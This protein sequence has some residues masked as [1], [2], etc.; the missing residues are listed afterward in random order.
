MLEI[1]L[2]NQ[3]LH[4]PNSV[5]TQNYFISDLHLEPDHNQELGQHF[6]AFLHHLELALQVRL[7]C[8]ATQL[9][10]SQISPSNLQPY[11]RL[12]IHGDLLNLAYADSAALLEARF[13]ASLQRLRTQYGLEIYFMPG[14]RDFLLQEQFCATIGAQ[15][16]PE[17]SLLDWVSDGSLSINWA[18]APTLQHPMRAAS[19]TYPEFDGQRARKLIVAAAAYQRATTRILAQ[20][21]GLTTVADTQVTHVSPDASTSTLELNP[22]HTTTNCLRILLCHGDNL[23]LSDQSYLEFRKQIRSQGILN[24]SRWIPHRLA[25][26]IAHYVRTQSK[27]RLAR[28]LQIESTPSAQTPQGITTAPVRKSIDLEPRYTWKLMCQNHAHMVILGHIHRQRLLVVN[29]SFTPSESAYHTAP[30]TPSEHLQVIAYSQLPSLNTPTPCA[31]HNT[32]VTLKSAEPVTFTTT[33]QGLL[34][35]D[36]HATYCQQRLY[37]QQG[38]YSWSPAH[39]ETVPHNWILSTADWTSEGLS[40]ITLTVHTQHLSISLSN[41]LSTLPEI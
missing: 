23:C 20:R 31:P 19:L 39:P 36:Y 22:T 16:L 4:H 12:F 40:I 13:V 18:T 25:H 9:T 30:T 15:L 14:N 26:A 1:N 6:A 3:A 8:A 7:R 34:L 10:Q 38:R 2:Q 33:A 37:T 32:P 11:A 5:I 24:L 35:R 21:L 41:D 27:Q 29:D 17:N 28:K